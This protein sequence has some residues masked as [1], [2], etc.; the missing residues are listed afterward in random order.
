MKKDIHPEWHEATVTCV[1]GN[2]W[3]THS[4]KKELRVELCS[5][6]H[7]FYTGNMR[8]VDTGG[9]VERFMRRL[10]QRQQQPAAAGHA[11]EQG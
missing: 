8:I 2:R 4:T 7:P 5:N 1:C 3:T 6:C 11:A 9:Q 10:R